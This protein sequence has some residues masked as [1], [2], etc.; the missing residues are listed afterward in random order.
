M[1]GAAISHSKPSLPCFAFF[2]AAPRNTSSGGGAAAAGAGAGG[3]VV[4]GGASRNVHARERR[5]NRCVGGATVVTSSVA[6]DLA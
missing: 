6:P 3:R 4:D 1:S 2:C 5:D